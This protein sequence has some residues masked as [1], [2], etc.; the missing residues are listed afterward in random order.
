[1]ATLVKMPQLAISEQELKH[2][3]TIWLKA[4]EKKK[5]DRA[6]YFSKK[7][8]MAFPKVFD[9]S[10]ASALSIMLGSLPIA[11]R[12]VGKISSPEEDCVELGGRIVGAIRPQNFDVCYRPDGV[13]FAFDSKGLSGGVD[14]VKKNYQN[15]L[16]DLGTEAATVHIRFPYAIVGFI[17]AIP[18]P[19]L[20]S[21]QKEALSSALVRLSRRQ[22]PNEDPH[23]AEAISLVVWK[24]ETG[25]ISTDWPRKES[26]L[27]IERFSEMIEACYL[28]RYAGMPPH[29]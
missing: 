11:E 12:N 15:M 19:S 8:G 17:V 14:S 7:D 29:D 16:N 27:R 9:R 6:E 5:D 26:P 10:V 22:N 21:P 2:W 23:R 4:D 25:Q 18:E 3:G 13:R 1:M 24:P 28:D 20:L